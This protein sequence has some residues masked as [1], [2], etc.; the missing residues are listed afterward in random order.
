MNDSIKVE[1]SNN[2]TIENVVVR[3][4]SLGIKSQIKDNVV[5]FTLD[6]IIPTIVE[7]N[8]YHNALHLFP[9]RKDKDISGSKSYHKYYF[10]PG[11]HDVGRLQLQN[12]DS[13]YI[14]G[15][16][17]VYGY[18]TAVNASN[19]YIYGKGILDGSRIPRSNL[20]YIGPGCIT[21]FGCDDISIEGIIMRD[22]NRWCLN[23]FGCRDANITN[24]KLIGLWR[25]NS[26]G[27]SIN[28]S[29]NVSVE[30]CFIRSADDALEVKGVKEWSASPVE[31][32]HF[33]KCIIWCDWGRSMGITYETFAPY[34]KN[35][36]FENCDVIRSAS[37]AV[38]ISHSGNAIVHNI[39][40]CNINIEF[41][42]W[43]PRPKLQ[44]LISE[45]YILNLEDK[46]CP[47]LISTSIRK[48]S[49]DNDLSID[50]DLG[51]IDKVVFEN[52]KV[53]G[54]SNTHLSFYGLDSAHNINNI[55]IKDLQFNNVL[56]QNLEQANVSIGPFVQGIKLGTGKVN[57]N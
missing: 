41:D 9:N 25:H 2:E 46:Y 51:N 45:R 37:V 1:I 36:T 57:S 20:P 39:N 42:E 14:A 5:S 11:I 47:S 31:N 7:I 24:V 48:N 23:L 3:P 21:L 4:L 56:L 29:Q 10:G 54:N 53:F 16:A 40:F 34:I 55:L 49:L 50:K 15:G 13:V 12:N 8:G 35:V 26:D 27:I 30:N 22:P 17:V 32:I 28:N 44:K 6:S 19:I 38:A 18:I 43:I 52:I 33:N